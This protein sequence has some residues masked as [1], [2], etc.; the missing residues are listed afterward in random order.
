[1]FV[2][3]VTVLYAALPNVSAA[4]D[5]TVPRWLGSWA[6]SPA[7]PDLGGPSVAGFDN[8]TLREVVYLHFGG[9]RVRVRVTNAFGASPLAL[10]QADL[11]LRGPNASIFAGSDR[12]LTFGGRVSMTIPAGAE[13]YSDPV[14]LRVRAG[15]ELS[16]SLFLPSGTGPT[17]WHSFADTT[18]YVAPGNHAS[19]TDGT[20]YTST[21]T[22]WFFLDG[23]DVA[24]P[25]TDNAVVALGDSITDGALS[26]L[27]ANNRWP[28]FL[29][30][31]L[32][33]QE[34]NRTSVLDEGIGG[35]RV[36][37]NA[38]CCGVNALARLDRDVLS[39][40][41]VRFV[42]LLEGI[43]DIGFS[44]L[45]GPETAPQ[46]DVSAEQII[47]GYKQI[48]A[49][50]HLKGLKV[51]GG[52]LTPFKGAAYETPAGLVK[53]DAVNHFVRT[54]GA[55]DAVID[56]DRATRDPNDPERFLPAFDSGDHLH[57]NDVGYQAMANAIAL[58]PFRSAG[59]G[60]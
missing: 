24:A 19:D 32:N 49:Q 7:P 3:L 4:E 21:T 50:V 27:D 25:R 12:K 1:M 14:N 55:F 43:N 37:N 33:S 36:L 11:A 46:T 15:Q 45:S 16:V 51:F 2:A 58:S 17:T 44:Q 9:D 30:R 26:T 31:R 13:V 29:S 39:Q 10:G 22:H 34:D 57:P 18:N 23:V 59:E 28:D 5:M 60:S 42:I 6:T 20:A 56:F 41:G 38:P 53:R 40:D 48:I 47:A 8:Q 35:N 54:S 52:T